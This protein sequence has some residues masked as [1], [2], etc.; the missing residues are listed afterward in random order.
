MTSFVSS[1]SRVRFRP[2]LG[3]IL[4]AAAASLAAC[5]SSPSGGS[6]VQTNG[7]GSAAGT[8][9]GA[10]FPVADAYSSE[11]IFT[12]PN[13]DGTVDTTYTVSIVLESFA[14]ICAWRSTVGGDDTKKNSSNVFL[15]VLSGGAPVTAG[16]YAFAPAAG[17][18]LAIG[19]VVFLGSVQSLDGD[20]EGESID[21]TDGSI[22]VA[23]VD[24]GVYVGTYSLTFP[25]G[26]VTGSFSASDCPAG[27]GGMPTTQNVCM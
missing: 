25:S 16:T 27:D 14:G 21:A 22:T 1:V 13:P 15:N 5:S 26:T 3:A 17:G 20:C 23:S 19:E 2:L 8:V 11:D 18:A 9:N 4:L 7:S 10:S 24:G 12:S 6:A